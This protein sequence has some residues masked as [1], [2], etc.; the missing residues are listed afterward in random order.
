MSRSQ[1]GAVWELLSQDSYASTIALPS[2]NVT[3]GSLVIVA[4]RYEEASATIT[5]SDTASGTWQVQQAFNTN[6]GVAIAWAY[7]HP[8]GTG[9]DI[10]ATFSDVR[11]F[12]NIAA[13]ELDGSDASD[14]AQVGGV[15]TSTAT[16][17][18]SMTVTAPCD[19]F[20]IQGNYNNSS[21]TPTSPA[22]GLT[23]DA[24]RL[25]FFSTIRDAASSPTTIAN[26]GGTGNA[27]S[28]SLAFSYPASGDTSPTLTLPTVTATGTTA[29]TG[30]VTTT[31][32]GPAWAILSSSA[33]AP[34]AA[35]IKV[36]QNHLG[37]ASPAATATLVVGANPGAFDFSG[38]TPNTGYYLHVVQDDTAVPANT[39]TVATS[40][41]VT[42][43]TPLYPIITL[44]VLKNNTGTLLADVVGAT[45]HVYAV[46]TGNKVVTKTGQASNAS[47]VMAITDPALVAGTEYRCVI[48][49]ASGAEGLQKATAA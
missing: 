45:V 37:T 6:V 40:A 29:V 43:D 39:S 2:R 11:P 35:Q 36:G 16:L 14:P 46:A 21:Y 18:H 1:I 5:L 48:V 33:I 41:T 19:I 9:V 31:E 12:R 32:A 17:N 49:L 44:P 34:T 30:G 8:G 24:Y 25:Y 38:L 23:T 22:V 47:A 7:N 4:V 28:I 27:S 42:T 26:T 15:M 20:A 13:I 10:T 3:A